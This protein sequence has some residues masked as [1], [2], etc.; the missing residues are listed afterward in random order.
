M[1]ETVTLRS[2][3]DFYGPVHKGIRAVQCRILLQLSST[4]WTDLAESAEGLDLVRRQMRFSASHLHHEEMELHGA[5]EERAPGATATL[6]EAHEAHDRAF[7]EIEGLC[8]AVEHA[9]GSDR[10]AAGRL[11]YLAFTQ[12]V[13]EDLVHMHEEETVTL[14][15]LWSLFSDA[16]LMA[17]EGRIVGSMPPEELAGG[18]A[19]MVPAM[20][21][22]ERLAFLSFA[23]SGAPADAF[24][25]MLQGFVRPN[26]KSDDWSERATGLGLAA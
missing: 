1:A 23:R 6:M 19:I 14:P 2:R 15:L 11:L 9:Q 3:H 16:E 25:A 24:A 26:L 5:L 10:I 12:F 4:D 21:P 7:V 17:M 8:R 22:Q 20:S 18:L 13:G